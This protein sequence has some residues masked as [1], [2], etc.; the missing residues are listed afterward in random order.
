MK[1]AVIWAS[2]IYCATLLLSESVFAAKL[3][4]EAFLREAKA[5]ESKRGDELAKTMIQSLGGMDAF[6]KI[7]TLSFDFIVERDGKTL[8]NR[9]H[10]WDLHEGLSHIKGKKDKQDVE[11]F[12]NL[13]DK[14]GRV[15][16]DGKEIV[17][18]SEKTPFLELGYSWWTNDSYWL[19]SPFK[20]FDQGVKR[21]AIG[22]GLRTTFENVG[23]TPG[24]GYIYEFDAAGMLKGWQFRLQS[25]NRGAF[26][27]A[28]PVKIHGVTF[29]KDKESDGFAIRHGQI[30][31]S[32]EKDPTLFSPGKS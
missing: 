20:A 8:M 27:F 12:L 23:L 13:N 11:L 3:P 2:L 24:D 25:K 21:A 30:R 1:T 28:N 31:G 22:K 17:D 5:E 15:F 4:E 18:A 29:F 26:V 16:V 9:I 14:S 32:L 10:H 19:V 6:R 7:R